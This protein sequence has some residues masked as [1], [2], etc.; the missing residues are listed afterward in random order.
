MM[1]AMELP[2]LFDV[3]EEQPEPLTHI[4]EHYAALLDVGDRDGYQV[5]A[6]FLRAVER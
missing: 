1:E 4:V 6:E 3:S 5:C 2:D